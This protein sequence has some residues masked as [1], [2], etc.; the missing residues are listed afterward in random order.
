MVDGA[1][2]PWLIEANTVP[3]LTDHSLVPMA[4]RQAGLD[5][6]ALVLRILTT[7]LRE[8]RD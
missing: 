8:G 4:A 1:G 6:E 7:S 5:F 3:G 2:R